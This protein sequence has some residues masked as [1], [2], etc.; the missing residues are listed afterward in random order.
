MTTG[1]GYTVDQ[2]TTFGGATIGYN[3]MGCP[4]TYEGKNLTWAKGKLSRMFSGT[5]T[6]GTSSYSYAYNAF[7][8]RVSKVY[9]YLPGK[10]S[11][12]QIGQLILSCPL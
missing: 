9:S 7:G 12:V 3:T 5:V 6:T 1:F 10:S 11:A 2:L 8:Q 4:T